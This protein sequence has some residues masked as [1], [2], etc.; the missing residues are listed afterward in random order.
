MSIFDEKCPYCDSVNH[1]REERKVVETER[2]ANL[3]VPL[4]IVIA[5][6]VANIIAAAAAAN[7]YSAGSARA[8]AENEERSD[9]ITAGFLSYLDEGD[10]LL[11]YAFY[12]TGD[13]YSVSGLKRYRSVTNVLGDYSTIFFYV[14]PERA[15]GYNRDWLLSNTKSVATHLE[16]IYSEPSGYYDTPVS[17]EA[18]TYIAG[19]TYEA[20]ALVASAYHLSDEEIKA[21]PYMKSGQIEETLRNAYLRAETD[22]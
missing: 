12:E 13:Y 18:L 19:I 7:A 14:A 11:A 22:E 4:V 10:Y 2:R 6:L 16:Y 1:M 3:V 8:R 20:Q 9:E 5:L 17:D 15:T 21:L